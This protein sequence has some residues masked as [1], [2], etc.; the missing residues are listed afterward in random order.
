MPSQKGGALFGNNE[1]V[2]QTTET[3]VNSGVLQQVYYFV[4]LVII[5]MFLLVL[6]HQTI[7]PIFKTRPGGKGVISIPGSDDSVVFWKKPD[8]LSVVQDTDT[9]VGT[10]QENWSFLLDIQLDNP[11]ANTD[12]PRI[13]MTRGETLVPPK[14]SYG[15]D[16]TI[17]TIAPNFNVI[18]YLDRITNDLTVAV[19]TLD[20][21]QPLL[22]KV[23]IENIP[24]RKSIRVG[25]MVGSRV[26]EVYVNGWLVR[27]KIYTKPLRAVPG[28]FQPP[29][30]AILSNTAR[31]KN[32]RLF[33]RPLSPAEFRSFGKADDFDLKEIADSCVA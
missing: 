12:Q 33:P 19:Q 23:V 4:G 31:V 17:L 28:S 1:Y 11:T 6:V 25:A 9:P 32:L 27:S 26:L 30:D 22:E 20:N 13:L 21:N 16:D 15:A 3:G 8:Q 10:T 29:S 5:L 2:N 7:T 14:M 24:I 18:V